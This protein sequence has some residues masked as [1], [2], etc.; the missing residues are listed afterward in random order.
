MSRFSVPRLLVAAA[1]CGGSAGCATNGELGLAHHPIDCALGFA[2]SDCTE[3]TRGAER[4]AEGHT[5]AED[6]QTVLAF[7]RA[8]SPSAPMVIPHPVSP[9]VSVFPAN[10]GVAQNAIDGEYRGWEGETVY[11]LLDG[12]V[13]RQANYYYHYHYAYSPKV[14]IYSDGGTTMMHV[15][16]DDGKDV[17]VQRL[18]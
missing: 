7:S 1:C 16:G 15:L 18:R 17:E 14:L 13:W 5:V 11:P 12:S 3:G 9:A 10:A 8:M 2:H 4:Y 6:L